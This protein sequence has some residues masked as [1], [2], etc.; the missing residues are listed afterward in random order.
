MPKFSEQSQRR[1]ETCHPEIQDV[2]NDAIRYF[3]F[4]VICGWRGE[5]AQNAAFEDGVSTKQWPDSKHNR[6]IHGSDGAVIPMSDAV[7]VAP[8]YREPPHVR[9]GDVERF[10][11]LAGFVVRSAIALGVELRWGGDWDRDTEVA[12]QTFFDLGHFE[13]A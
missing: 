10:Y 8:Y 6:S 9:W 1:L 11:Y 13:R 4:K 12:D 2:M 3:D 7:D 5:V